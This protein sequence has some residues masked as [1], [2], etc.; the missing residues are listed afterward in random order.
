M[1]FR[2]KATF[3]RRTGGAYD[4][5]GRWQSGTAEEVI[6]PCSIQALSS[7][8]KAQ[9]TAAGYTYSEAVRIYTDEPLNAATY[10]TSEAGTVEGD[11][12]L[13]HKRQWLVVACDAFQMNVINHYRSI[14][15][16]VRRGEQDDE[17]Q[18]S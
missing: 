2:R 15:L 18:P 5:K 7:G 1:S 12:L 14:A 8:E 11:L 4:D 10:A 9:L 3:L 16:E 6:I 17:G 13:W